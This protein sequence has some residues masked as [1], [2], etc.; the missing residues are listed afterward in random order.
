MAEE[1]EYGLRRL[2]LSLGGKRRASNEI[3]VRLSALTDREASTVAG[4]RSRS[5]GAAGGKRL[6]EVGT[7]EEPI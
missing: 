7:P 3:Q 4:V 6:R 5:N 1:Q 2:L